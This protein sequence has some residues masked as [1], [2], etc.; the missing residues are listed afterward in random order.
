VAVAIQHWIDKVIAP[1]LFSQ[2]HVGEGGAPVHEAVHYEYRT[3]YSVAH[4]RSG[5]FVA[6]GLL[7]G[8]LTLP[9]PSELLL[10][11]DAFE[12]HARTLFSVS[13]II[14]E[15]NLDGDYSPFLAI[16]SSEAAAFELQPC[17][18]AQLLIA[19]G[20]KESPFARSPA[21]TRSACALSDGWCNPVPR[22]MC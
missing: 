6:A 1:A 15:Q 9:R 8:Q 20:S 16:F 3:G 22:L 2:R 13:A 7:K 21:M 14:L 5:C 10:G 4:Q 17:R 12:R 18:S 11:E 19:A